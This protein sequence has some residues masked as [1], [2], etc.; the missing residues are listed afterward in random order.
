MIRPLVQ[1][2]LG[3]RHH[4]GQAGA[5]PRGAQVQIGVEG[6]GADQGHTPFLLRYSRQGGGTSCRRPDE[7]WP[8]GTC[9]CGVGFRAAL[10]RRARAVL[11]PRV[12]VTRHSGDRQPR[13]SHLA[14]ATFWRVNFT[15][16]RNADEKQFVKLC[17]SASIHF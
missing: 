16:F 1:E 6:D 9:G 12:G 5:C 4:T 8:P 2:P 10:L 17:K 15:S 14:I 13:R 11:L 7:Q 3:D